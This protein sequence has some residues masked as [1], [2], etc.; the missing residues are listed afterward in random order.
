MHMFLH[1]WVAQVES[2][3]LYTMSGIYLNDQVESRIVTHG[4][5]HVL[6]LTLAPCGIQPI[7][8]QLRRRVKT[9]TRG[10]FEQAQPV[11]Q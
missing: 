10:S 6:L 3:L 5:L 11:R 4:Q 2:N 9:F 1:I 7:Q 8:M